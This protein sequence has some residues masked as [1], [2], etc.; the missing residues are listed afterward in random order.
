[1]VSAFHYAEEWT[2][3]GDTWEDMQSGPV[4]SKCS[5]SGRKT[6]CRKRNMTSYFEISNLTPMDE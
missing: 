1:M 3:S 5:E 6:A 2:S 4:G